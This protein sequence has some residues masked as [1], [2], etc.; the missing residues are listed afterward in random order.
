MAHKGSANGTNPYKL[1]HRGI[2]KSGVNT[3][4]RYAA[5]PRAT[6]KGSFDVIG[7][8]VCVTASE[9]VAAKHPFKS[10]VITQKPNDRIGTVRGR[11][12][13]LLR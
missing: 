4:A 5:Q 13:S 10:K 1:E 11:E 2:T 3:T 9:Q 8:R 6:W 12:V 7:K